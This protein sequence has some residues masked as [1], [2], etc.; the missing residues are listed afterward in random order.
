MPKGN[1]YRLRS[2]HYLQPIDTD[3]AGYDVT[4]FKI[5]KLEPPLLKNI[6]CACLKLIHTDC[7]SYDVTLLKIIKF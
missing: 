4:L 5:I 6:N 1:T 3:C 2:A 7:A